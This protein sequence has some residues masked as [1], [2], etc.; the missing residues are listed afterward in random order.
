MLYS[1]YYILILDNRIRNSRALPA[2]AAHGLKALPAETVM[3][4]DKGGM[5]QDR[6]QGR[7]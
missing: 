7:G 1:L 5:V 6:L 3:V 2:D 4:Y